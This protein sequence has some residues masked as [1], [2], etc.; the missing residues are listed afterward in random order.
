MKN[1]ATFTTLVITR[2]RASEM[3]V[4]FMRTARD[5]HRYSSALFEES[6]AVGFIYGSRLT[7]LDFI[8]NALHSQLL[9]GLK[10][11]AIYL[12]GGLLS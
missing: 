1:V 9:V 12:T 8:V 10:T 7:P 11:L 4:I 3:Q 2:S 5:S 6:A